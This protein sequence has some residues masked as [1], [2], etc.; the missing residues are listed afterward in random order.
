MLTI[1]ATGSGAV[2]V[3]C[4]NRGRPEHRDPEPGEPED[5]EQSEHV[6][7][8]TQRRDDR[9]QA[10]QTHDQA[11]PAQRP[12]KRPAPQAH[13]ADEQDPQATEE[14]PTRATAQSLRD[15]LDRL[16]HGLR[17]IRVRGV[18][19]DDGGHARVE[20]HATGDQDDGPHQAH[21]GGHL[22]QRRRC[23]AQPSVQGQGQDRQDDTEDH[24]GDQVHHVHA[25]VVCREQRD[26]LGDVCGTGV[27][28]HHQEERH[29]QQERRTQVQR[30]QAA[31]P[32][33]GSG[34]V[35]ERVHLLLRSEWHHTR[36]AGRAR[37]QYHYLR[38]KCS[39]YTVGNVNP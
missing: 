37:D 38:C 5:Q 4:R 36:L 18:E 11:Q 21:G 22:H 39:T 24:V 1:A 34:C 10:R 27:V 28:D 35:T 9:E 6:R 19:V 3:C 33:L 16:P 13:D 25:G 17:L 2:A 29:R 15:G 7:G 12:R 26:L 32:L 23:R 31:C 14:L 20:D 30:R 8:G